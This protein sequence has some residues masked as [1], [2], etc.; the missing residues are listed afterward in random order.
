MLFKVYYQENIKEMPVREKTRTLYVE[1][2]SE[3]AVRKILADR[4]YNI[5]Y[6]QPVVGNYLE[7]EKSKEYFEVLEND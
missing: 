7:Y 1:A 3:R 5:E 2:E 4:P 6:V